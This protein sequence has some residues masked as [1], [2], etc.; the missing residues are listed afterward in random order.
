MQFDVVTLFPEIIENYCNSSIIGRANKLDIINV[1]TINPRDFSKNKHKRVDDT[2]YGG[3]A[4]MVLMCEPVFDAVNSIKEQKNSARILLT[5][6]GKPFSQ[7]MA[8]ELSKKN[9]II[10]ICG[11]YE[12]FDER[13]R[14]NINAQEVSIGD[15]VLTGGELPALCLIDAVSRNVEGALGKIESA[16]EDT[17]SD[18]F[19][20]YPQYTKPYDFEGYKVPDVLLSGH[21]QEIKKWRR[22][23]Q[24][25]RTL[26]KRPDL[27][28]KVKLTKEDKLFL[29]KHIKQK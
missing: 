22:E 29:D 21:H 11:H 19:I 14:Q 4:G 26:E 6:Q 9:Q 8:I 1:N 25:L 3:G 5:P 24:L 20:E 7:E 16:H 23:Q 18:G 12:G 28:E 15:F 17:F 27:L 2:P 13:I 10:L